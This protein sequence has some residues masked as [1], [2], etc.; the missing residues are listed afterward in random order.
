MRRARR[1]RRARWR[2]T[3]GCARRWTGPPKR[4][5]G[6]STACRRFALLTKSCGRCAR[7]WRGAVARGEARKC[8]G[9]G[10]WCG[11]GSA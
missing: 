6:L 7:R 5:R 8:G 1:R 10:V 9:G 2:R 11:G 4:W 3:A